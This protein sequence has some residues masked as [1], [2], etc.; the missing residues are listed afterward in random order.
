[1]LRA[2]SM[3]SAKRYAS[4]RSFACDEEASLGETNRPTSVS[5]SRRSAASRGVHLCS[6]DRLD[7]DQCGVKPLQVRVIVRITQALL[8]AKGGALSH[9]IYES[10]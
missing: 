5:T 6:K 2:A 4:N 8:N 1:M 7:F 3:L 10:Q 9:L